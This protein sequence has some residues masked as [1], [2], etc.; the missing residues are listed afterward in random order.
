MLTMRARRFLKK[1]RRKLTVNDNETTSFVM[2]NV[3]YYNCHKR[4]H[5][6]R[7]CKASRNQENKHKESSG[8][9]VPVETPASTSLVSCDGLG[10]YDWSD[11]IEEE[12][13]YTLMAFSSSSSDSKVSNDSTC[14][15][16]CLETVKLLKSQNEQLLKDLKKSELMVLG[17]FIP[18]TPDLSFTGLD[19]FVNKLVAEIYKAKSSEEETKTYP[20]AKKNIVLRVVLM[21]SGLVNTARQ[22]NAAH[23]KTTVNATRSMYY[24]SKTTHLTVKNPIHKNTAFE[25]SNVNQRV[26][27]VRRNNFNTT[28]PKAVVNVVQGNNLNAA[29]ASACW[30]WKPNTK[31]LDHVSKHNSVLITLKKFDYVDAQGRSK[32]L[33]VK[34]H[35]KTPYELFHGRTPTLSFMRSFGCPVTILNTIDHLGK[36]DGKADEGFFVRYYLNSKSF[37]VFNSRTSIVEENLHIKFSKST[38]NVVGTKAT[39][40]VGQARKETEPV[41]DYILLPL[42]TA[43]SPFSQDPKSS[44]DDGSKPS[45]DNGKKIDED[46]R[47]ENECKDQEKKDNVNSA[48]N[49]NT[50]SSNINVAGTNEDNELPFAPNMP[51]LEDVSIFNFS[52]DNEDDGIVAD[53]NNL[54]TT[55]QGEFLGCVLPRT[56]CCVLVLCFVSC[57]LAL[58]FAS[59]KTL[60]RFAKEKPYQIQNII[61]F[62]LKTRCVLSQDSLRFVSKLHCVLPHDCNTPKVGRSGILSPG[63][64]TS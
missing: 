3:D 15:K 35:N 56:Q 16:S 38:P 45:S 30:V 31:V 20:C 21:K 28:R 24:L 34:P 41:K 7:E 37:R 33:V 18:P 14:S 64:V 50:I 17:N 23:S 58:R 63:R 6:A 36:Y 53:M 60:L 61:A 43:N 22:V 26:N 49:V 39:D 52:N 47:K 25:S 40:N 2:S 27:T 8:K 44:Y 1:T 9:S 51:G 19:E 54:D 57:D 13:N 59:L 4:G 48:N 12:P 62:C 55:I 42:W 5:F 29:K 11:Q 10:G 46:L 32:V